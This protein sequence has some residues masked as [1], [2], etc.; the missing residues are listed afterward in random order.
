MTMQNIGLF[1][2]MVSKM[3]YL[4]ERQGIIAQNVANADTP[5]YKPMDL[6]E[7]DFGRVLRETTG[8]PV[9]RPVVTNEGHFPKPGDIPPPREIRQKNTYEV[10]PSGNAVVLEEQ[11]IKAGQTT[12]EFSLITSLYQK[13]I[14]MMRTALGTGR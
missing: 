7:V 10:S 9:V 2:A 3:D 8:A 1:K 11:L 14:G 13:N 4:E 6:K 12:M 5:N